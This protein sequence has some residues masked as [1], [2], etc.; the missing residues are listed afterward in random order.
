MNALSRN[1]TQLMRI[2]Q[3]ARKLWL[4]LLLLVA[5]GTSTFLVIG[6]TTAPNIKVLSLSSDPLFAASSGDK[7]TMALALSVEYPTVGA[8][9]REDTYSVT[10]E[11]LGYY[12]AES[13]Y[14]YNNA[15]TEVATSAAN[16]TDYKRFDKIGQATARKCTGAMDGFSGNFLNFASSSTIDMLRLALAGGDR[17][18]DTAAGALSFT[19]LQRAV[20]SNGDPVCMWNDGS[21]FPGKAL[22]RDNGNYLGAVPQIMQTEANNSSADIQ[23]ANI[24]NRVYFGTVRG[25]GCGSGQQ[26]SYSLGTATSG[27]A[28]SGVLGQTY[29]PGTQ[30]AG[31]TT[32]CSNGQACGGAGLNEITFGS[33]RKQDASKWVSYATSGPVTCNAISFPASTVGNSGSC[34]VK[35]YTGTAFAAP[36]APVAPAG[37][38]SDGFFFARVQVC[39]VDN[40]GVLLDTRDYAFCTKYPSGGYKPTGSIQKYADQLRLAA[41][42]YLMDQTSS[43]NGGRYGGVLRA[44]MKYVGAKTFDEAGNENTPGT[45]NPNRE[46]D[47]S[48]GIFFTNPDGDATQVTP[49]SGVINYLNKFGRIGPVP[50]RYKIYDPV[51]ELYGE[52]LR[53]LQGLQPTAEAISNLGATTDALYDG[54]PVYTNW[55]DPYGGNRSSTTD[56]SCL[57][58]NIVV[59]G[60]VNAHDS[61]RMLTRTSDLAANLPDFNYWKGIVGDFEANRATAYTDGQGAARTTGNPNP[62]NTNNQ[63]SA[64]GN[65]VLTGAA[66]WARTQDIR[67]TAWTVGGTSKQRKGLR[68][69]SFFFDANENGSSNS[70][71]YRQNQNQYFTAGKYGGFET[72]ANNASGAPFNTFGN[73]FKRQDGTNDNNVWQDPSRPGEASSYYLAS[74]ARETLKAFDS[75]FNRAA[76]AARSIAKSAATTPVL[77]AAGADIYQA[78]FDTADWSGDVLATPITLTGTSTV[79]LNPTP[80]W[81]AATRLNATTAA[82]RN[83]II[84]RVGTMPVPVATPFTWTSVD[85]G[86]QSSL[87]RATPLST[88]D[89]LGQDRLNYLRGDKSKEGINFRPRTKLLG[90]V[91]NSGVV[92]SGAPTTNIVPGTAAYRS[93]YAANAAR[94]AAVFAGANDGMMHAFNAATG[95]ELFGYIPSWIID[96]LPALTSTTYNGNHQSY[97]DATPVL[98]EAQISATGS[99]SDWKTVLVSGTGAGGPGV[100]ALDVTNPAAFTSSNVMWEFTKNDDA[101][102]GFVVGKPQILKIRTSAFG[103]STP[104]YRWFAVVPSGVNN[105]VPFPGPSGVFSTTGKPALFFLA[106]DKPAGTP[107]SAVGVDRNY[108]KLSLPVDAAL[109]VNNPTGLI[110]FSVTFGR[111]REVV[112]MFMGDLHGKVWKL[113][114]D[115]KNTGAANWTFDVLSYYKTGTTGNVIAFPM[116]MAKAA[117]G[118]IQPISMA[119]TI[120]AATPRAGLNDVSYV[121]FGTGKYLEPNDKTST[122]QNSFMFCTMTER[123]TSSRLTML[124]LPV[125]AGCRS[126]P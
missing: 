111:V 125:E 60:D 123:P 27:A 61:N 30:P 91:I 80:R 12:D 108:Y 16:Y 28:Q 65:V 104:T 124:S 5:V 120:V 19:I 13:C 100:F 3:A 47:L 117:S 55:V 84:G 88:S 73:P 50:G 56:Y 17:L 48:T 107:W 39:N 71:F 114:F 82:A 4:P 41:F 54:F 34:L 92:Y 113:D 112:Q 7:P 70:T 63:T 101:D 106:L 35:P 36:T 31:Y 93:F 9:Y 95:D 15:P 58:S 32:T 44:P 1:N 68:V 18:I 42:G 23:I 25:G 126:A 64:S 76:S 21:T 105:Y 46:W 67:G 22:P 11:Y 90:D 24:L 77:T 98:G 53:Y 99:A 38:N 85:A 8:Q 52:S 121:T 43:N 49:A 29:G 102:M 87:A 110:N 51:G 81:T 122:L 57:K 62:A 6:Q 118:I 75:I 10:S 59:V 37:S 14:R 83:I 89:T 109:A 69:K 97:V 66:Y 94:T 72:D 86:V 40:A 26:S 20:L 96:K 79:A 33:S 78:S 103:A 45:G 2:K 116:F 119:P 115:I 74:S